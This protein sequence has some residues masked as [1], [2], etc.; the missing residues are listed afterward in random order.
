MLKVSFL[1]HQSLFDGQQLN[2]TRLM[3]WSESWYL[4]GAMGSGGTTA[5]IST[6]A[7]LRQ[8]TLPH[9]AKLVGHRVQEIGVYGKAITERVVRVGSFGPDSDMSFPALQFTMTTQ[10][11]SNKRLWLMRGVP[12][13]QITLG[14]FN[15]TEPYVRAL[16]AFFKHVASIWRMKGKNLDTPR[17]DLISATFAGGI[18]PVTTF[19]CAANHGLVVN[20]QATILRTTDTAQRQRGQTVLV[21]T[22]PNATSFTAEDWKYGTCKGG[23]VRL[24]VKA[25]VYGRVNYPVYP[26]EQAIVTHRDTGRPFFLSRGRR[27]KRTG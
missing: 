4:D 5:A 17:V 3:G 9:H 1:L 13:G 19:Q 26:I 22:V 23:S 25:P 16:D 12:D 20:Q 21:K 24:Y 8:A 10:G 7:D 15:P 6:Y 18:P 14:G 11:G 27:S 2:A